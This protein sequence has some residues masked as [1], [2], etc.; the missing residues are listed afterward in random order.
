MNGRV[1]IAPPAMVEQSQSL[2]DALRAW[3]DEIRRRSYVSDTELGL[4]K[5]LTTAHIW[6]PK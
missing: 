1:V 5:A 4:L 2:G 3:A 6:S